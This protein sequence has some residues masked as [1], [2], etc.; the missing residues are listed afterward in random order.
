MKKIYSAKY[1]DGDQV[2]IITLRDYLDGVPYYVEQSD[3]L[4]EEY[5]TSEIT[6]YLFDNNEQV[7][8]VWIIDSYECS[9]FGDVTIDELKEMV[10]SIEEG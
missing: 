2:L 7:R 1:E 10:N 5:Q 8:S 9:I 6:Y 4:I 3:G